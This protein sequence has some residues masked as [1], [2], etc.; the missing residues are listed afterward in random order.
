[1]PLFFLKEELSI[2]QNYLIE[3]QDAF[4][5]QKVLRK[6][7][8]QDI[9][10]VGLK[11]QAY[12]AKIMNLGKKMTVQVFEK[13]VI[14]FLNILPYS[15]NLALC[16]M[17]TLLEL[18]EDLSEIGIAQL[19]LFPAEHSA[20]LWKSNELEKKLLKLR[21][22]SLESQKQCERFEPLE[23]NYYQDLA[24]LARE[25]SEHSVFLRER[26]PG[27]HL[28]AFLRQHKKTHRFFVGPEGGWHQEEIKLFESNHISPISLGPGIL[29][30]ETAVTYLAANLREFYYD[31]L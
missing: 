5:I 29:R 25:D 28:Q 21:H 11:K 12:R 6:G 13:S 27:P 31:S 24:S 26:S 3:A 22:R 2:G 16:K 15:I 4:H 8:G 1:M 19:N 9:E 18:V 30:S 23:I 10:C 14:E 7:I 20:R 17:D